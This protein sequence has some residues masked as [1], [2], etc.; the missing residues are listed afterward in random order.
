[1]FHKERVTKSAHTLV[2]SLERQ[3]PA[4][5]SISFQSKLY[6]CDLEK[7]RNLR[8]LW[9]T[10]GILNSLAI[11]E[12]FIVAPPLVEQANDEN[13]DGK[14]KKK[15]NSSRDKVPTIEIGGE[16][17]AG[18]GGSRS[19]LR[20]CCWW[21]S[22]S[23]ACCGRRCRWGRCSRAAWR[24]CSIGLGRVRGRTWWSGKVNRTHSTESS[25]C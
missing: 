15:K 13:S 11:V 7:N 18:A 6:Y 23:R 9:Q 17:V 14:E 3:L 19:C 1:M 2:R 5:I 20:G 16:V 12:F 10:L 8:A 4:H 24:G 22:C 25:W 21:W